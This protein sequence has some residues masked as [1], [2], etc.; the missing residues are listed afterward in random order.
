MTR[1][2]SMQAIAQCVVRQIIMS[3]ERRDVRLKMWNDFL[4][5]NAKLML[6]LIDIIDY[7]NTDFATS[8]CAVIDITLQISNLS[9]NKVNRMLEFMEKVETSIDGHDTAKINELGLLKMK[10][11]AGN[12]NAVR[13]QEDRRLVLKTMRSERQTV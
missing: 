6:K 4:L 13:Y 8:V 11:E 9:P 3:G 12:I 10:F 5:A 2:L 1:N 7:R